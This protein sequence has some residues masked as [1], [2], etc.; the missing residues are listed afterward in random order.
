MI[1]HDGRMI[2]R[3]NN[4]VRRG[5]SLSVDDEIGARAAQSAAPSPSSYR[6]PPASSH[7]RAA[8]SASVF[9]RG[10]TSSSEANE[11]LLIRL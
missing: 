9:F 1:A 11:A 7:A 3:V 6:A 5:S 4:G 8:S 2:T 10:S